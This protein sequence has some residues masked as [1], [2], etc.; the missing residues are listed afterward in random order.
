MRY[1]F[2]S[3]RRLSET[4]AAI[5][6]VGASVCAAGDARCEERSG[7]HQA[8]SSVEAEPVRRA[9]PRGLALG[10]GALTALDSNLFDRGTNVV[11]AGGMDVDVSIDMGVPIRERVAWFGGASLV[12]S[13][14][15]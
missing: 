5:L 14:R 3:M 10:G 12:T 9:W 11:A 13:T 1:R 8:T 6:L 15:R 4:G 2:P 7:D